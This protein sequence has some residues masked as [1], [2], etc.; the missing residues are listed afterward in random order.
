[1]SQLA[2]GANAPKFKFKAFPTNLPVQ[3]P[4]PSGTPTLLVFMGYQT[5][6][7][8]EGVVST[9][10]RVVPEPDRLLIANVVGLQNVPRLMKG[11]ARKIIKTAYDEA[12]K[13]IPAEYDPATQLILITDWKGKIIKQYGVGNVNE[14]LTVILVDEN[15]IIADRYQGPD[16]E[17]QALEMVLKVIG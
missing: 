6:V 14:D 3:I 1:M 11:A 17:Q 8:I 7:K 12:S 5:A 15:G 4:N 9:I 16:A 13:K 2:V 10:R